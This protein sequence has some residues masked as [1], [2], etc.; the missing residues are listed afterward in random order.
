MGSGPLRLFGS[1]PL[2]VRYVAV[3]VFPQPANLRVSLGL[4]ITF[5]AK[6]GPAKVANSDAVALATYLQAFGLSI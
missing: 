3:E 6:T 4:R 2:L 5:G 1:P